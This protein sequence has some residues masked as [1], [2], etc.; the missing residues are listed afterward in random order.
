VS[1][2]L[3]P[4]DVAGIELRGVGVRR[5]RLVPGVPE[6]RSLAGRLAW[7]RRLCAGSGVV[8]LLAMGVVDGLSPAGAQKRLEV[9]SLLALLALGLAVVAGGAEVVLRGRSRAEPALGGAVR[10]GIQGSRRAWLIAFGAV[11]LG[12]A[13]VVQTWYMGVGPAVAGGDMTPPVGT[14]WTDQTFSAW[15][16][17]GW[18]VGSPGGYQNML[19]W[20]LVLRAVTGLGGDPALAQRV[21]YTLLLAGAALAGLY[22]LRVLG[23]RPVGAAVGAAVYVLNPYTLTSVG[24]NPVFLCG[25]ILLA[26]SLAL[27]LSAGLGRLHP[28]LAAALLAL[29]APLW[30]WAFLNPPLVGMVL[31]ALLL[32][33]LVAL[34]LGGRRA[35]LRTGLTLVVALPLLALASAYWLVVADERLALVDSS[36]LSADAGWFWTQGRATLPNAFWLNTSWGWAHAEYF[37]YASA[38]DAFPLA[39]LKYALP[40]LAFAALALRERRGRPRATLGVTVLAGAAALFLVVLATGTND[41]GASIFLPLYHLP[42]GWLLREPG[43]FLMLAG[44]AYAILI[45]VV[46][47]R[48]VS[49]VRP[50]VAATARHLWGW[51]TQLRRATVLAVAAAAVIGPAFPLVTGAVVADDRP[52]LPPAHVNVPA[53][54]PQM[55]ATIDALPDPGAVLVLPADDFYQM[56][57]TWG[58]YGSDGFIEQL[59]HHHVINPAGQGYGKVSQTLLAGVGDVEQALVGDAWT[60]ARRVLEGMQSPYVLVRGDVDPSYPRRTI[61][62][63]AQIDAAL[64][65]DPDATLIATRGP[66]HLYR[67]AMQREADM[68]ATPHV[69]TV[70][71]QTPDLSVLSLLPDGTHLVGASP[72]AGATAMSQLPPLAQWSLQ[73][74]TLVAGASTPPGRDVS[75]AVLGGPAQRTAQVEAA[76]AAQLLPGLTVVP[77]SS[78]GTVTA[79]LQ[80]GPDRISDGRFDQGTWGAVG[81]CYAVLGS[82]AAQLHAGVVGGG[83]GGGRALQLSSAGDSACAMQ[84]VGSGDGPLLVAFDVR[85]VTGAFPRICLWEFETKKCS[86]LPDVV[87]TGDGWTHYQA[88]TTP[89]SGYHLALYLYGDGPFTGPQTIDDY[90]NVSVHPIASARTVDIVAAAPAGSTPSDVVFQHQQGF[91]P[92]WVAPKG[93]TH[94]AVDGLFDGWIAPSG[95]HAPAVAYR[96]Q[97]AMQLGNLISV[98]AGA[99]AVGLLAG[100]VIGRRR[101]RSRG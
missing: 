32:S 94:A 69:V 82:A 88:V 63:P 51:G 42:Y 38:Y 3:A 85:H 26:L 60:E 16:W 21:M 25:L 68:S 91:G 2:V 11:A 52:Q 99:L 55:A 10:F 58:Y 49:T 12:A 35:A 70:D 45:G 57:Y 22:L 30:G 17:T 39:L 87:T 36:G 9:L 48:A 73:G 8:A 18:D 80:L 41:P 34:W 64:A 14:A 101:R 56:P 78:T 37:P 27:V 92:W 84:D 74:D 97:G 44:L 46:A 77:D 76:D 29:T 13:A 19:P 65:Q 96:P 33:P 66:L 59:I 86:T 53:Y 5:G 67:I 81:D 47:D 6:R 28:V 98:V 4:P 54:W 7:T 43:R 50:R 31:L 72:M 95:A 40:A 75:V 23:L 83:P 61:T 93:Y 71:S 24:I 15:G 90:A 1:T 20:A 100:A 89:V 62:P 79:T